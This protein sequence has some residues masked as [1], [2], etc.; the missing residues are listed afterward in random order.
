[1]RQTGKVIARHDKTATVRFA[2][3]D[4]CGDC[5][6]CFRTGEN[7]ADIEIDNVLN[8]VEGDEVYIEMHERSVLKASIIMYGIPLAALL[9]GV[10]CF[11]PLGDVYAAVGGLLLLGASFFILRGL[12]PR[13]Q[14]M[15]QFKPRMTGF[16]ERDEK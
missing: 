2:R 11:S 14:K 15:S 8:A 6:A 5:H 16:A 3:S 12:E 10:I 4:M 1:M 7:E 9:I 13:F